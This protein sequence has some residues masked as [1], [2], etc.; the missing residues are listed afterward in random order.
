M[1]DSPCIREDE[2]Q[3]ALG[4][5]RWTDELRKHAS[6]CPACTEIT[7]VAQFMG[8]H[9]EE[10]A[11]EHPLPDPSYL[12]WRA[13]LQ[14]RAVAAERA[15]KII[16]VFQ[17]IAA[18]GGALLAAFLMYSLSPQLGRWLGASV[19]DRLSNPLP[20]DMAPPGLVILAS[21]GVIGAW[22]AFDVYE[23]W[24]ESGARS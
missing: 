22:L 14:A 24:T 21:I 15:T 11:G 9:S 1:N 2:V 23:R 3:E 16:V 20:A 13:Q 8:A 17:R 4:S 7:T 12:W 19:P 6:A 10:L 18:V 5:G